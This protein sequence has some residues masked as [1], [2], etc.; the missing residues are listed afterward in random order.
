M[1]SIER[2]LLIH[3]QARVLAQQM[4]MRSVLTAAFMNTPDPLGALDEMRVDEA[5]AAEAAV[6]PTGPYEDEVWTEALH[7]FH[8]ELNQVAARIRDQLTLPE[9]NGSGNQLRGTIHEP[10]EVRVS[11]VLHEA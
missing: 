7:A 6:R 3:L 8:Y 5:L 2:K 11:R 4:F 9:K 1:A 10:A